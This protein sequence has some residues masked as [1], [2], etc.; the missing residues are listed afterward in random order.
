M[1]RSL[2]LGVLLGC[3][4]GLAAWS[5]IRQ[6][7]APTASPH[8][9]Q[10]PTPPRGRQAVATS[11][12]PTTVPD[13]RI[14]TWIRQAGRDTP[15]TLARILVLPDETERSELLEWVLTAWT[16]DDR[17]PALDWLAQALPNM[18]ED[19]TAEVLELLLGS[20]ALHEPLAA[21]EW[22][23]AKLPETWREAG[24]TAIAASWAQAEPDAMGRWIQ[25]QAD[26]P[27]FW[28]TELIHGLIPT[29][30]ALALDWCD[31]LK[32]AA[33]AASTHQGVILSWQLTAPDQAAVWL[34]AHPETALPTPLENPSPRQPAD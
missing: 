9:A 13:E 34:Q 30:P 12:E 21:S 10:T 27:D 19:S 20:W 14:D 16:S 15:G 3:A 7:A 6:S 18:P 1:R 24:L 8:A 26:L 4:A 33:L 5:V 22:A 25:Q 28:T 29:H 17:G 32:D 11:V 31:R 2:R 23:T